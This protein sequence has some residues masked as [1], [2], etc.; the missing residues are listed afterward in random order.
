MFVFGMDSRFAI[1]RLFVLGMDAWFAIDRR[2][3]IYACEPRLVD[4]NLNANQH[5]A[6]MAQ[7]RVVTNPWPVRHAR[8]RTEVTRRRSAWCWPSSY[9]RSYDRIQ[10][11]SIY[12]S[13]T[14]RICPLPLAIPRRPRDSRR[15]KAF[16]SCMIQR[17]QLWVLPICDA[18]SRS[19]QWIHPSRLTSCARQSYGSI[20]LISLAFQYPQQY[21][22]CA[23]ETVAVLAWILN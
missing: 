8:Q 5:A 2:T 4:L 12:H 9:W 20:W 1:D 15:R 22:S 3:Y 19:T 17:H 18:F 11:Y 14:P 16:S 21:T 23:T 7:G 6:V 10:M 13:T